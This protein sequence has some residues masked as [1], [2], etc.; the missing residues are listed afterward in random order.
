MSPRTSSP[1]PRRA[2]AF[3]PSAALAAALLVLVSPKAARPEP[4]T[5]PGQPPQERH[6]SYF[7]D[8]YTQTIRPLTRGLDPSILYRRLTGDQRE[9]ANVDEHDQ[10]RLPSTWWQPRV[11]FRPVSVE[12][13]LQGPGPSTGPAAGKWRVVKAKSQGV[14]EGFQIKDAAGA[15]FAIKFDPIA[16]SELTTSADVIGAYLY[17]AAGYNVPNNVI[18]HFRREDLE[19]ASDAKVDDPHKGKI[20]MTGAFIDTLLAHVYRDPDGG[21]RAVAS[22][23]IAGKPLGEFEYSGRRKDDPEDLIP[24]ELRRELRGLWTINSWVHHDDC[25]SRNTLDMWVTDGGRSFVRHHLIDF[26]GILGAASIDKHSYRS[27]AEYLLDYGVAFKNT[28]TAGLIPGRWESYVDPRMPSVGYYESKTFDPAGWRPFLPNPAFDE[29]TLRD[30]R[31][32][33]KIVA[34]FSDELIRAAVHQGKL[35]DPRA[36]DYLVRTIIERRDLIVRRWLGAS[37]VA[38]AP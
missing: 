9:A 15:R 8:G 36:E 23:F 34:G 14:S 27:G 1:A 29:R 26:N 7:E 38:S 33:A 2:G 24:H 13:M 20:P 5:T 37:Y 6:V 25:A 32:G 16:Y 18:V 19:I 11:G 12:Q 22:R 4:T 35:S 28:V 3:A 30:I 17:W 10:V 31:W 21:Y